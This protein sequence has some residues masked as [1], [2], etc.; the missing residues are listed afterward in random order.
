V[1]EANLAEIER[2]E[3]MQLPAKL[4]KRMWNN[5]HETLREQTDSFEINEFVN[6]DLDPRNQDFVL[7]LKNELQD[8]EVVFFHDRIQVCSDQEPCAP[9]CVR[10]N[11]PSLQQHLQDA[12]FSFGIK[13]GLKTFSVSS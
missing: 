6:K 10:Y 9:I 3:L 11:D 5:L 1:V 4:R 13:V 8:V 7:F 2:N 12:L